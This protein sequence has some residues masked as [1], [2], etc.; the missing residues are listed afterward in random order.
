MAAFAQWLKILLLLPVESTKQSPEGTVPH[1]PI[2]LFFHSLS[3]GDRDKYLS[4]FWHFWFQIYIGCEWEV[5]PSTLLDLQ[6]F[7][8]MCWES[9]SILDSVSV[10]PILQNCFGFCLVCCCYCF[11]LVFYLIFF[12]G[13]S[14]LKVWHHIFLKD[15]CRIRKDHLNPSS[16][17]TKISLLLHAIWDAWAYFPFICY[18][19]SLLYHLHMKRP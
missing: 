19:L 12:S 10:I 2:H 6:G 15:T 1:C 14:K 5:S 4:F 3:A 7:E 13:E 9:V 8:L 18:L 16:I 17:R 11:S